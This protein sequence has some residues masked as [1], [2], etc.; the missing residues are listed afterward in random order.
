MTSTIMPSLQFPIRIPVLRVKQPLGEFYITRLPANVLLDLT[1]SDPLR[2]RRNGKPGL[3]YWLKGSQRAESQKR[4]KEIGRYVDTVEAAFPNSI[5]L[6]ANY[7]DEGT[8]IDDESVR[9]RVERGTQGD[10][11]WLV[12]PT[13]KKLASIIDGQH[14][15][16]GFNYATSHK[17]MDLLCSV[18]IDLPTPYQ[19]YLFATINFNQKKVDRS[20]AYELF[21]FNV[22]DEP[23]D[24]WS[25]EKLAVF[26]CR[27]LNLEEKSPLH[28][29]IVVA[30]QDDEVLFQHRPKDVRWVVSTATVVDGILRLISKNPKKDKDAMHRKPAASGRSRRMLEDDSS[31]MRSLYLE[32]KDDTVFQLVS[33]YFAV[34]DS[35]LFSKATDSSYIFRTVGI[36]ALFDILRLALQ[37]RKLLTANKEDFGAILHH[38]SHIDF[39]EDFFQ[40]SGLGRT[41]IRNAI[42]L[43]SGLIHRSEVKDIAQYL[44]FIPK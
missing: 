6:A 39:S 35:L 18:Y 14:R 26:L 9:W 3:F 25:P 33:D 19:A 13:E 42:G 43:A 12:I 1:F 38:G 31:P 17:T 20:L 37:E 15:L 28:Q 4:L 30:A 44:R 8:L 7:D 41:R 23:K 11:E 16:H 36:Q 27:R 5:I 10:F 34:A 29:H 32:G 2:I 40:A 24:A 22:E 21:G